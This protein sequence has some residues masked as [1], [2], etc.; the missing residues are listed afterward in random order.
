[1]AYKNIT[2]EEIDLAVPQ[3]DWGTWADTPKRFRTNAILKELRNNVE[4]VKDEV[5]AAQHF[6]GRFLSKAALSANVFDPEPIYGNY[7]IVDSDPSE[8]A[9]LMV[10]DDNSGVWIDVGEADALPKSIIMEEPSDFTL[11]VVDHNGK[12]IR[13]ITQPYSTTTITIPENLPISTEFI[14]E[15]IG[16]GSVYFVSE[17]DA[18]EPPIPYVEIRHSSLSAPTIN[19]Q[20]RVVFAKVVEPNVILLTGALDDY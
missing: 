9:R 11:S 3:S 17:T 14:F 19:G 15:S 12:W 2:D 5:Y 16:H 13:V 7:A 1:M 4:L 20:H 10:W 18:S 6:R 8:S